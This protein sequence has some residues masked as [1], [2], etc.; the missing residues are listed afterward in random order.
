[1]TVMPKLEEIL[2]DYVACVRKDFESAVSNWGLD[3]INSDVQTVLG[4]LLSRQCILGTEMASDIVSW[5]NLYGPLILRAMAEATI[6]MG[7]IS[8][9]PGIRAKMFIDYGLGQSKLA[10]EQARNLESLFLEDPENV[11]AQSLWVNSQRHEIFTDVNVGQWAGSNLEEM[12]REA[13]LTNIYYLYSFMVGSAHG[14]WDHVFQVYLDSPD[15]DAKPIVADIGLN[16][17]T[18]KLVAMLLD[19]SFSIFRTVANQAPTDATYKS[20]LAQMDT[21]RKQKND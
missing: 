2:N 17:N 10:L 6:N 12:A 21:L 18:I 16:P 14:T 20:L 8:L 7:W 15:E 11:E 3:P 5:N 9:E 4:G 13:N 1:M 19:R